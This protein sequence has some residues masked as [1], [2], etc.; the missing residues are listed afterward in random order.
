MT[1]E[2]PEEHKVE[3]LKLNADAYVDLFHIEMKNGIDLFLKNGDS[4]V[5]NYDNSLGKDITWQSYPINFSGYEVKSDGQVSRPTLQVVNPSGVWSPLVVQKDSNTGFRPF[6]K[7]TL[8]RYRVLRRDIDAFK[9]AV[10]N[11]TTRPRPIFQRM[12]WTIWNCTSITKDYMV[13]ECRNPMDGNNFY[14]PA[15]QYMPPEF[16]IVDIK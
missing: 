10:A 13:F 14:I 12:K 7:A 4:V 8:Y 6:E 3:N 16:P 15:R 9:T 5:W 1:V 2:I 11:N